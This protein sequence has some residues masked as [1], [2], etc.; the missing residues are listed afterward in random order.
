MKNRRAFTLLEM[1]VAMTVAAVLMGICT[2]ILCLL[3]QAEHRGRD[4]LHQGMS[5]GRLAEQFRDDVHAAAAGPPQKHAD[6]HGWQF[7]LPPDRIVV[8][9]VKPGMVIRSE[10]VGG[11]LRRQESY[12]LPDQS[13][14]AIEVSPDA[15]PAVA[16]LLLGPP[17]GRQLR[18]EA[19]FGRDYRFAKTP[20]GRKP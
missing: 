11:A 16:C 14:A 10:R 12:E 19:I 9:E 13:T 5:M 7:R 4:D 18:V 8:Y 15:R 3:L 17:G 6:K 2:G 20:G 1:V